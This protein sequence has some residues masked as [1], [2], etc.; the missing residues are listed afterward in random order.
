MMMSS[1]LENQRLFRLTVEH[2]RWRSCGERT[3]RGQHA[4]CLFAPVVDL[5]SFHLHRRTKNAYSENGSHG[6]KHDN[7]GRELED[8]C[9][10]ENLKAEG[11]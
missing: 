9:S 1:G 2:P 4:L 3:S 10:C 6:D 11:D 8:H 5:P 7:G